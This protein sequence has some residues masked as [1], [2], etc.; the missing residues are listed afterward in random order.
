[1]INIEINPKKLQFQ[2]YQTLVSSE[3]AKIFADAIDTDENGNVAGLL[4]YNAFM[5]KCGNVHILMIGSL[6]K[7]MFGKQADH[8]LEVINFMMMLNQNKSWTAKNAVNKVDMSSTT[9]SLI[10]I[11]WLSSKGFAF[12]EDLHKKEDISSV[13]KYL[14]S[15]Y[16]NIKNNRLLT[17]S[18]AAG[19][20]Y[21]AWNEM[22]Q[23]PSTWSN[24]DK[25][26]MLYRIGAAFQFYEIDEFAAL[27]QGYGRGGERKEVAK[28]VE[29]SITQY[30]KYLKKQDIPFDHIYKNPFIPEID[31]ED[32]LNMVNSWYSKIPEEMFGDFEDFSNEIWEC[33]KDIS[34]DDVLSAL[35]KFLCNLNKN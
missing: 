28:R 10:L 32:V 5:E 29:D 8:E 7:D 17:E 14:K 35:P 9:T 31:N 34:N 15:V 12:A 13:L 18:N 22:I 20:F 24:T 4:D 26:I 33:F 21:T 1:M 23:W 3:L 11:P 25:M 6:G 19:Y 16:V 27:D 30:K 2:E